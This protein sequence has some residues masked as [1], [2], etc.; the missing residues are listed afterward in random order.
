MPLLLTMIP[1]E[2]G[3]ADDVPAVTAVHLASFPRFFLSSLGPRFLRELYA[4]IVADPASFILVTRADGGMVG[5]V[6]GT[7]DSRGLYYRLIRCRLFSFAW[8]AAPSVAQRPVIAFR[9]LRALA[10]PMESRGDAEKGALLMSIAVSPGCAGRG[11]GAALVAAF[12]EEARR[13]GSR[14]IWLTTDAVGNDRVNAFYRRCGF[15]PRRTF[16]TPEGRTMVEYALELG[17]SI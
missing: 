4:G 6:A 5:F 10:K 16:A 13:R 7:V 17:I 9:I 3:N 14:A 2:L 11:V 8:A 12:A 15:A 1:I